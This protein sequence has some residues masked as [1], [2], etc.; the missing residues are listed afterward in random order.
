[1]YINVNLSFSRV[2]LKQSMTPCIN[3]WLNKCTNNQKMHNNQCG[4]VLR[5]LAYMIILKKKSMQTCFICNRSQYQSRC[6]CHRF[7]SEGN[8]KIIVKFSIRKNAD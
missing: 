7:P 4:N 8:S 2:F 6:S 1:M 5:L 3:D